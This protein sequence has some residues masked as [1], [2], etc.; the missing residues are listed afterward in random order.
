MELGKTDDSDY[1][2]ALND[3]G[4]QAAEQ[5]MGY[6]DF[7]QK[8][9]ESGFSWSIRA[10]NFAV[11]I[12]LPCG[13][14]L[15]A[16]LSSIGMEIRDTRESIDI[17]HRRAEDV[18]HRMKEDASQRHNSNPVLQI[19][20]DRATLEIRIREALQEIEDIC[21]RKIED[22]IKGVAQVPPIVGNKQLYNLGFDEESPVKEVTFVCMR[23]LLVQKRASMKELLIATR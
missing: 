21:I 13:L 6:D 22:Q 11:V 20:A 10:N 2:R 3:A 4:L 18:I 14:A 15:G 5:A 16:V 7:W 17:I 1:I 19:F 8:L 23:E 9:E 12:Y